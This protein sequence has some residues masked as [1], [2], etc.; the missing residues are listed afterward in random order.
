MPQHSMYYA[1]VFLPLVLV[2]AVFSFLSN[3]VGLLIVCLAPVFLIVG[4]A[5]LVYSWFLLKGA[6]DRVYGSENNRGTIT[7]I[8]AIAG[9]VVGSIIAGILTGIVRAIFSPIFRY[10]F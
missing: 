6:F 7:A 3:A 8:V 10:R 5:A 2:N 4:I 1:L 9:W